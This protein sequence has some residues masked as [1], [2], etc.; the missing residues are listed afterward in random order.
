M[1]ASNDSEIVKLLKSIDSKLDTLVKIQRLSTPKQ[2]PT[3][4]ES[5]IYALCNMKHGVDDMITKTG[6]KRSNV[7]VILN[8]LRNKSLI[9]SVN[10]TDKKTGKK[11]TVYSKVWYDDE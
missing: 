8:S 4:E 5:K 11:K 6:K 9:N 1:V 10:L 3:E 7:E 2:K